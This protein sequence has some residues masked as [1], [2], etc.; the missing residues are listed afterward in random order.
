M[1]SRRSYVSS[2][3]TG[4]I[5]NFNDFDYPRKPKSSA[6][7]APR[8][9][10]RPQSLS[11]T[12][13]S[14]LSEDIDT[15]PHPRHDDFDDEPDELDLLGILP[16]PSVKRRTSHMSSG[17]PSAPPSKSPEPKKTQDVP[18]VHEVQD[19]RMKAEAGE[20]KA[21]GDASINES[22]ED[23]SMAVDA[24]ATPLAMDSRDLESD[25]P[26]DVKAPQSFDN[27]QYAPPNTSTASRAQQYFPHLPSTPPSP[28]PDKSLP[29]VIITASAPRVVSE[30]NYNFDALAADNPPAPPP[31]VSPAQPRHQIESN[32]DIPPLKYL[33][34]EYNRKTKSTKKKREKER[35]KNEGRRDTRDDWNPLGLNRWAATIAS[36]PVYKRVSKAHKCLS[37]RDWAVSYLCR[38]FIG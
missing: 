4:S 6:A 22:R 18:L 30:G 7:R 37:T 10:T 17:L 20:G 2:V 12:R 38:C 21:H 34:P 8:V 16:S 5:A 36:N 32:Y 35:E 24:A 19:E 13:K 25:I 11:S 33:P 31:P 3:E 9:R 26:P 27:V 15:D 1:A 14:S 23:Y 29:P 28:I